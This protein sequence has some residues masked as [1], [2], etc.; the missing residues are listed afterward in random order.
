[1]RQL[2]LLLVLIAFCP[3]IGMSNDET[4][5]GMLKQGVELLKEE[6][7]VEAVKIL[8]KATE[9][10]QAAGNEDKA[11][12]TNSLLYWAKKRMT[13]DQANALTSNAPKAA[14]VA[15]EVV[16][17]PLVKALGVGAGAGKAYSKWKKQGE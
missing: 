12:E 16:T 5:Q 1:M 11:M 2:T 9:A 3:V 10:F 14:K 15:Q 6:K 13:L 7:L 4:P 17:S 8:A